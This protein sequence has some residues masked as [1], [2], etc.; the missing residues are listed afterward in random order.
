M[1]QNYP[2]RDF[3]GFRAAYWGDAFTT[4]LAVKQKYDP[5]NF[6]H[7]EQSISPPPSTAGVRRSTAPSLF[8]PA[9][10]VRHVPAR[11]G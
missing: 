5:H 8:A 11:R 10:I 6:F 7:F 3:P 4:L 1:Y 9:P 2:I